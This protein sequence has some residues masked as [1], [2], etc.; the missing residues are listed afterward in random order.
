MQQFRK[1]GE[2]AIAGKNYYYYYYMHCWPTKRGRREEEESEYKQDDLL[3][4]LTL[5]ATGMISEKRSR[6]RGTEKRK[7]LSRKKIFFSI[8]V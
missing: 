7:G 5:D 4:F 6:R 2:D 3:F 1:E 8:T